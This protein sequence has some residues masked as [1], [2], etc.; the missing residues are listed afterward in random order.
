MCGAVTLLNVYAFAY[1]VLLT[2][3]QSTVTL[4][5]AYHTSHVYVTVKFVFLNTYLLGVIVPFATLVVTKCSSSSA[6]PL[7]FTSF[8]GLYVT[9]IHVFTVAVQL[10]SAMSAV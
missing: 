7:S 8:T 4:F 3:S 9:V 10:T 2:P 6:I 5:N 1:V